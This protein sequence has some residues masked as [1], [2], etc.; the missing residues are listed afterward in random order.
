MSKTGS[1]NKKEKPKQ[2]KVEKRNDL[3][4]FNRSSLIFIDESEQFLY[5]EWR[6]LLGEMGWELG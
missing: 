4:S 5:A 3:P 1:E 2:R 6:E